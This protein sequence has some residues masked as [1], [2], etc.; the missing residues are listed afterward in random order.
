MRHR[1]LFALKF[2]GLLLVYALITMLAEAIYPSTVDVAPSPGAFTALIT[3]LLVN[4]I[5]I[6]Y[7]TNRLDLNVW[8]RIL[9]TTLVVYGIQL[10][11]TQM[12]TWIFR[13]AFP[14]ID[15]HELTRLFVM[16]FVVIFAVS[17]FAAL[18][19]K[20]KT[21]TVYA[22]QNSLINKSWYYKLPL[23]SVAYM[24]LYFFFGR[25]VAFQSEA[26]REFYA[27]SLGNI[28]ANGLIITQVFRGALWVL[29]CLPMVLWIRAKRGE[30]II[31]TA[32]FMALLPTI[33]LFFPNPFMP[34]EIRMYHFVEVFLSN[35]IFGA[36]IAF[37][38]TSKKAFSA[39]R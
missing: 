6:V 4:S 38:L 20:K 32:L 11:M 12:E 5:A 37:M 22:T 8:K 15:N 7:L 26:L 18:L 24:M 14:T 9:S 19:W 39:K 16:G 28:N 30:K 23:L 33:L 31:A 1:F 3:Q 35:G 27:T 10:F 21:L 13:E 36:L 25:Y 2:A 29:L 17:A 34:Q